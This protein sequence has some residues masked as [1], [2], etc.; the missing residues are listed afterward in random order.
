M[1]YREQRADYVHCVVTAQGIDVDLFTAHLLSPRSG[2][3]ATRREP[4]E[5]IDDWQQNFTDR[6]TQAHQ[7]AAG[8]GGHARP[9]ILAGDLNASEASP[10]I[11]VL[12]E[13]GLRDAFSSA[14]R[15]YGYTIGH[16][17]KLGVSFLR[18]DHILV[19]PE[20]GVVDCF[21]G[22]WRASEHRPVIADLWLQRSR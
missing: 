14:G 6:L 10:V 3:N 4:V 5:G 7:L 16:A 22:G 17:L 21:P 2:L 18:I 15:G 8:V 1:S 19:S 9:L 11:R 20:I 12:Q 13:Q